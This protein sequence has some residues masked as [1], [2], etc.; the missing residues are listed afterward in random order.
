MKRNIQGKFVEK[1]GMC[2]SSEYKSWASM[3]R[4]CLNPDDKHKKYKG[5][6]TYQKW[7]DSFEEFFNDMGP[8]PSSKHT[9]ERINNQE[10]YYPSNCRWATRSEQNKNYSQ[11]RFLQYNGVTLCVSDWAELFDMPRHR[12]YQRLDK[13]W[14]VE[15]AL[16]YKIDTNGLAHRQ[17]L[18]VKYKKIKWDEVFK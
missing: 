15:K 12:I 8:K 10:G 9:I 16:N 4:R 3:K 18:L 6:L 1:H 2:F 7:I 14:S 11:N 5:L 17:Q 13:G